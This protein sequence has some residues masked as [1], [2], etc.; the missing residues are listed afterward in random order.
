LRAADAR[1]GTWPGGGRTGDRKSDASCGACASRGRVR[2]A[3]TVENRRLRRAWA[4][5]RAEAAADAV[6]DD[7]GD[8][9]GGENTEKLGS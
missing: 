8:G 7:S 1:A 2:G 6:A 5:A 9:D 3:R 4:G